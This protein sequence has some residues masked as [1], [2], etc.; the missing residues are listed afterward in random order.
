MRDPVAQQARPDSST[1]LVNMQQWFF[2][3]NAALQVVRPLMA[4][5]IPRHDSRFQSSSEDLSW[6]TF[7]APY[8]TCFGGGELS[9]DVSERFTVICI[10]SDIAEEDTLPYQTRPPQLSFA[11]THH[12]GPP[13]REWDYYTLLCY[14]NSQPTPSTM[15]CMGHI[16]RQSAPSPL[17]FLTVDELEESQTVLDTQA[18]RHARQALLDLAAE[19]RG[20]K[21]YERAESIVQDL[22]SSHAPELRRALIRHLRDDFSHWRAVILECMADWE[23]PLEAPFISVVVRL[24][25]SH[26]ADLATAAALALRSG[27]E[28]A[29]TALD[30]ALGD[31]PLLPHRDVILALIAMC[32]E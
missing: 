32:P 5:Q 13:L 14:L 7:L 29:S 12:I 18:Y 16:L 15:D 23:A 17:S 21:A 9:P 30:R 31:A 27:G 25:R 3:G 26:D 8:H 22:S 2:A 19:T 28:Y 6:Q 24:L 4:S 20:K 1:Q 10:P 11:Q